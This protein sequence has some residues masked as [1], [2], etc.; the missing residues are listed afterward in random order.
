MRNAFAEALY[1][2]AVKDPRICIVCA[3]ISPAGSMAKFREEFP[4]R[5][6]NVGVAEQVMVGIAAGLA[7]KGMKVFCYTI[8]SFALYRAFEFVRDDVCYQNLDVTIVGVGAGTIYSTLGSTH[9]TME[10]IAVAG[11][12]PNMTILA[13]CDPVETLECVEWIC[14]GDRGPVYLRLGKAG[15]PIL[16]DGLAPFEFGKPRIIRTS[17]IFDK[18][19]TAILTY[20][21]IAALAVEAWDK[22]TMFPEHVPTDVIVFPT[23]KPFAISYDFLGN[24]QQKIVV[25][26]H[27]YRGGLGEQ[28]RALGHLVYSFCLQD[29]FI[30]CYGSHRDLLKAHG[31]AV[32]AII[33]VAR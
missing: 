14:A 12:L 17:T 30:H 16:I 8:A 26:D 33:G 18:K 20:G 6:I 15:E 5:F 31:I 10:D 25:E 19:C 1:E 29:K 9:H 7:L 22:I 28:V 2:A 21:P 32:D 4:D 27:V 3:D 11:A 23:L 13:P 24:Y